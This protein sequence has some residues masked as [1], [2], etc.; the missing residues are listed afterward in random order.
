MSAALRI[1]AYVLRG[2]RGE[3][4]AYAASR[5]WADALH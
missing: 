3:G 4:Y 2:K 1:V 5:S